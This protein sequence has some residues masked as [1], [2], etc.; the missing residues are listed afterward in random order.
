M[1]STVASA[2]A[3]KSKPSSVLL[4]QARAAG[5]VVP[6]L[7]PLRHFI[8]VNPFLGLTKRSFLDAAHLLDSTAHHAPLMPVG[9]YA[10][11]WRSGAVEE[12]DLEA[13]L[14]LLAQL[15]PEQGRRLAAWT[16]THLK[17]WVHGTDAKDRPATAVPALSDLAG[18]A[19]QGPWSEVVTGEI[20]KFCAAYFD[21]G[22]ASWRLPWA[23]L[24]LF[25]A[26]REH[27]ALDAGM[28]WH[29]LPGFRD[30][31]KALP[32]S[33]DQALL[34]MLG[35]LG[36]GEESAD[37]YL[38][39]LLLTVFGWASHVRYRVREN[40]LAGIPDD[41]LLHLL[42]IRLAYDT[43]LAQSK[44]SSS[45]CEEWRQRLQVPH[46][47]TVNDDILAACVW[48]LAVEVGYQRRLT[49]GLSVKSTN[50]ET[51]PEARPEAQAVFCIDVRSEVFRR[52]L[53]AQS[54]KIETLGFAGF[55]GMA[56]EHI[57]FGRQHG[58]AQCPALIQPQ[59]RVRER[60]REVSA[61]RE[62][63]WLTA[64]LTARRMRHAWNAF[65]SSAVSCFSFVEAAGL[66]FLF[67]LAPTFA[68]ARAGGSGRGAVR[69]EPHVH[70]EGCGCHAT[71]DMH[72]ERTGIPA[73]SQVDLAQGALRHMGLT[74]DFARLVLLCGHGSTSVNN[75][76]ASSLDCGACG[77]HSGEANARVAATLLNHP[78]VRTELRARGI[79][80]PEDT[81]FVAGLHDTTTDEVV[82]FDADAPATHR[83]D[84]QQLRSWL[85][86]A[87]H[88]TR[89][90]R[91]GR[92]GH[93]A[94]NARAVMEAV[95][96]RAADWSQVRPEWGLAGNA[97]FVAAPRER[98]RHL[99]LGGRVFLHNY[100]HDLDQNNVT[101]ELILS[102]PVVVASW[103]NLQYYASTVNNDLYGSGNK[104]LHNV[105]G[106]LG[107]CLGNGG[108]LRSGLPLQSLHNGRHWVHEP[109][110]LS[111]F[112]EAPREHLC[113][114]LSRLPET[115][116][117]FDNGW[118]HLFAIEPESQEIFR[119][120]PGY[121][122]QTAA[123]ATA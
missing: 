63:R 57:P 114:A 102:A 90:Q 14:R 94:P 120:L 53:E 78:R 83:E 75:P 48:Q 99:N 42:A 110:R 15:A 46:E 47:E 16:P 86:A 64:V 17:L 82:L 115:R 92:L 101:L 118:L 116:A 58:Y 62:Q 51:T 40:E 55:F 4:D 103:I 59:F 23:S 61:Q 50:A 35:Q 45:V 97:A 106:T 117:L 31:V 22:Q 44:L 38:R 113:L 2:A 39:R 11:R 107:V 29:G 27:A 37:F 19:V 56:I 7:W 122:W 33:A 8:A 36:V 105:V 79:E 18:N 108:D 67:K 85:A 93:T 12:G 68:P 21:E 123:T 24:P 52:S 98:T 76:Y 3:I 71:D 74:R 26:W 66:A 112:I 1:S 5:D 73:S 60:P 100:R 96:Q 89:C 81:W 13:A 84:L 34:K 28:E 88:D 20:A 109:L 10:E 54:G 43:A 77:G 95:Q 69:M 121:E 87:G 72:E 111:V 70:E 32:A 91:S 65:K 6:P 104:V 9:F 41:S 30:F 80:V 49:R 25:G 119:Y